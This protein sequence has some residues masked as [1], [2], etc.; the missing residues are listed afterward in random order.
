L[1]TADGLQLAFHKHHKTSLVTAN[2][3]L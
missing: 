2:N 1:L 3:L